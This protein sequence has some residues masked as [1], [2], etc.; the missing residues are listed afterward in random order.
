MA[1]VSGGSQEGGRSKPLTDY[2]RLR[3][4]QQLEREHVRL[5]YGWVSPGNIDFA[6]ARGAEWS[7]RYGCYI[8][9]RPR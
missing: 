1:R 2:Q 9:R 6:I 7:D 5:M 3:R 4:L 8:R